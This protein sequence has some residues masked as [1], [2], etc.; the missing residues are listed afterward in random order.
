MQRDGQAVTTPETRSVSVVL[1][2]RIALNAN[3]RE[4][5][6]A[7]AQA[8]HQVRAAFRHAAVDLA[9][10]ASPFIVET[11]LTFPRRD[12]RRDSSN[13]LYP[14][15]KAALD[16]IVDAHVIVDDSDAHVTR[17]VIH[18]HDID[19]H[20]AKTAEDPARVRLTLTLTETS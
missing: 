8:V 11:T 1:P 7:V 14:T 12:R 17:T 15:A 9:P 4:H 19:P 13:W 5:Y 10:L 16:G 2:A 20:L 18:A 3:G 6:R